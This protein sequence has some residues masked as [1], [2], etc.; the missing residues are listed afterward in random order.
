LDIE[1]INTGVDQDNN[2]WIEMQWKAG[3]NTVFMDF[4]A[5]K[6]EMAQT[7]NVSGDKGPRRVFKRCK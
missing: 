7:A 4:S 6:R 5:D 1:K 2:G 3:G